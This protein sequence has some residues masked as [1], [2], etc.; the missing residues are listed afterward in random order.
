M[1]PRSTAL[2]SF[3]VIVPGVAPALNRLYV[4]GPP[5]RLTVVVCGALLTVP[6][7]TSQEIVRLGSAPELVGSWLLEE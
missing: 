3:T 5:V 7:L 1:T 4:V 6:S 2:G